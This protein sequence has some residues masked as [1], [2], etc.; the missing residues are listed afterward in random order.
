MN[1]FIDKR[2]AIRRS[3]YLCE[4]FFQSWIRLTQMLSS[5]GELE[6]PFV[7]KILHEKW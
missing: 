3:P 6:K 1:V 2:S 5:I 7:P 4:R